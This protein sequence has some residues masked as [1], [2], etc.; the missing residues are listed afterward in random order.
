[1]FLVNCSGSSSGTSGT[2]TTNSGTTVSSTPSFTTIDQLPNAL[3][4]VD[5]STSAS[6]NSLT[7]GYLFA[8]TGMSLGQTTSSDFNSN[9]SLAACMA[10][11]MTKESI[12]AAGN[13]TT[14]QCY[15][16][17]TFEAIDENQID[18]LSDI[19]IYD[20]EPHIFALN[21]P[22]VEGCED[23]GGPEKIRMVIEKNSDGVITS[24]LM[25]AC[26]DGAQNQFVQQTI[27]PSTGAFEMLSKD[28]FDDRYGSGSVET[29][30]DGFVNGSGN[31]EGTKTITQLQ[32]TNWKDDD[33]NI[34]GTN[35]GSIT[36]VQT[37]TGGTLS[38][39]MTGSD[40]FQNVTFTYT[41]SIFSVFEFIDGNTGSTFSPANLAIGDGATQVVL[42][43]SS[44]DCNSEDEDFCNW[45][46]SF[47]ESWDGDTTLLVESN[48]FT[49]NASAGTVPTSTSVTI[50][51]YSGNQV[52]DCNSEVEGTVNFTELIQLS[53]A[54]DQD[55]FFNGC[56]QLNHEWINCWHI[57]GDGAS[58][59]GEGENQDPEQEN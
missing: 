47:T 51:D 1:M 30:V 7:A 39:F 59:E 24:F 6:L 23:C 2:T 50:G 49:D 11:N 10:V 3:G 15:I 35:E 57:A 33:G 28:A 46:D 13:G 37:A 53:G 40:T 42:S 16:Q 38:G 17:K 44:T 19:D 9:S 41:D 58:E 18:G 52:F 56:E 20:G 22:E 27:N 5:S 8:T 45:N 25:Q 32:D 21:F 55:E 26:Q 29:T 48:D 14:V 54:A 12:R 4:K 34:G 43:G 31:F 36:L